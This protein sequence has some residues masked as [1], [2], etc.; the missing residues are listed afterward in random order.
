MDEIVSTV[1]QVLDNIET[2][3]LYGESTNVSERRFHDA[4]IKNGKLFAVVQ[5]HG[6]FRFAPGKFAGYVNNDISH[7]DNLAERD[8][9]KT[10][11]VLSSLFGE[12]LGPSDEGYDAI[13]QGFLDYCNQK[14]ILPSQHGLKRRYWVLGPAS[15][16]TPT[17]DPKELTER[18]ERALRRIHTRKPPVPKGH[19]KVP[20][21][22]TTLERYVRDPE[23]IAWVLREAAGNCENCGSAAPFKRLNGEPFLEVHHVRSLGEGGPDTTDNAVVCCPNCHRKLHFDKENDSLR[24]KLIA[25]IKRLKDFPLN[26]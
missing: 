25:S 5:I 14:G 19:H 23:V 10:N 18:V 21:S 2:L 17:A 16:E 4:R 8:G 6:S 24:L 26:G 11:M 13:D 7:A 12:A 15:A 9:R 1:E 3:Y 20:K 22:S